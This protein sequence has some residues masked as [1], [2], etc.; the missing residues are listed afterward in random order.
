[1]SLEMQR[2]CL[3]FWLL[4]CLPAPV[5]A[6]DVTINIAGNIVNTPC[7]LAGGS[8]TNIDLGRYEEVVS[9]SDAYNYNIEYFSIKLVDCPV[10]WDNV[11]LQLEGDWDAVNQILKNT[12]T[13]Q[14]IGIKIYLMNSSNTW[15]MMDQCMAGSH[16]LWPINKQTGEVN[17]DFSAHI[18]NLAQAVT[19]GTVA[20]QIVFT[21][22]YQ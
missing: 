21:L 22:T 10:A 6:A 19:A 14:N 8:T 15:F 2:L 9:N 17:I 5:L 16:C 7:T 20:G 11:R 4:L 13:A 1:M 18:I 3:L 12:G